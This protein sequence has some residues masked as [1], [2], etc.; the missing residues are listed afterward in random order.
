MN[1]R[2][3]TWQIL[4]N[5]GTILAMV[6]LLF[7]YRAWAAPAAES[8]PPTVEPAAAANVSAPAANAVPG[9][10]SYQG[11]LT[12][13]A[14]KPLNG[15]INMIFCLYAAPTGGTALWTEAH[16]G[17]N[18]V[19]VSNG[20]FNVFLGSLTP[21]P[22]EVWNNPA[23]YLGVQVS[24]DAEMTPREMLSPVPSAMTT[25]NEQAYYFTGSLAT[26]TE[27]MAD[28]VFNG[29]YARFCQAIGRTFTHAEELQ[30]HYT[31]ENN[32]GFTGRG[33]GFFY[34]GWYYVGSRYAITDTHVYGE[35]DPNSPYSVW[36]YNG[37]EGCC[38][39][40]SGWTFERSA[41]I[42]CK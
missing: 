29:N 25:L 28:V 2:M 20:L 10:I 22:T 14:G 7:A 33:N 1:K 9:V 13:A 42:W 12:D 19:P 39:S 21:I 38:I 35:T 31:E 17:A 26:P 41:I 3:M 27:W 36:K 34:Q 32:S 37:G 30:A 40:R 18:A 6:L 5:V 8:T 4:L 15:T 16:T 11:T 23:L 24:S